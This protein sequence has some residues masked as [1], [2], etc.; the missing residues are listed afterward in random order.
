M[1]WS[2]VIHSEGRWFLVRTQLGYW[3]AFRVSTSASCSS[4]RSSLWKAMK[5]QWLTD[6]SKYDYL[7]MIMFDNLLIYAD[8]KLHTKTMLQI[9]QIADHSHWHT[10]I[11]LDVP[12]N[13][14]IHPTMSA[15]PITW[16][17]RISARKA[18]SSRSCVKSTCV[19]QGDGWKM[20][21]S[22]C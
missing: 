19:G 2:S 3:D 9:V 6:N 16:S 10:V 17:Y 8:H 22:R 14:T 21:W 13:T 7:S 11:W 12:I 5:S 1:I 15:T 18:W 20:C 4:F